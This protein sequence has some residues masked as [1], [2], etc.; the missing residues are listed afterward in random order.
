MPT[1]INFILDFDNIVRDES[2]FN[3][4]IMHIS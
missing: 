2:A 4:A 3:V 1:V